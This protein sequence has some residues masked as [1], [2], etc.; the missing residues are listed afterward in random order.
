[1]I[2]GQL[3][4]DDIQLLQAAM[5]NPSNEGTVNRLAQQIEE[6]SF[7]SANDVALQ[8]K[9]PNSPLSKYFNSLMLS[10]AAADEAAQRNWI[11]QRISQEREKLNE[12]EYALYIEKQEKLP[13]KAM[14]K[15]ET[16]QN[17]LLLQGDLKSLD[18]GINLKAFKVQDLNSLIKYFS[19][20]EDI[21]KARLTIESK[22]KQAEKNREMLKE[23]LANPLL[24]IKQKQ[25]VQSHL[26][27]YDNHLQQSA[28]DTLVNTLEKHD[29]FPEGASGMHRMLDKNLLHE[30]LYAQTFN[31]MKVRLQRPENA[32]RQEKSLS[33]AS[34]YDRLSN[35][36]NAAIDRVLTGH[37]AE[38]LIQ[39]TRSVALAKISGLLDSSLM[40]RRNPAETKFISQAV[41]ETLGTLKGEP[42]FHDAAQFLDKWTARY[43]T[44]QQVGRPS[45]TQ[46][47]STITLTPGQS[48]QKI[49]PQTYLEMAKQVFSEENIA[50]TSSGFKTSVNSTQLYYDEEKDQW[51]MNKFEPTAY[52]KI[53]QLMALTGNSV[54]VS[55]IRDPHQIEAALIAAKTGLTVTGMT[56]TNKQDFDKRQEEQDVTKGPASPK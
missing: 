43:L 21:D 14:H 35:G 47:V 33:K 26:D 3:N 45:W 8:L 29:I 7:F 5:A 15:L 53:A 24:S 42:V 50:T 2:G 30:S 37:E 28:V 1:M 56:Q 54:D 16:V 46:N 31:R 6:N 10:Y 19:N 18:K 41:R 20:G 17:L 44:K 55:A 38:F 52:E 34:R 36:L 23:E 12:E 13:T 4:T 51:M 49:D 48:T 9:N 40:A 11:Q 22:Y 39:S 27:N 32:P 25:A